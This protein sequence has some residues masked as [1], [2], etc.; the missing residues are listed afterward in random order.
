MARVF[1]GVIFS[2]QQTSCARTRKIYNHL[3]FRYEKPKVKP[4]PIYLIVSTQIDREYLG[5]CFCPQLFVGV[6]V[7]FTFN[8]S[9]YPSTSRTSSV[10]ADSPILGG[11]Q[12]L[13][14]QTYAQRGTTVV[15][16]FVPFSVFSLSNLFC[17]CFLLV[18]FRFS[19]HKT[20]VCAVSCLLYTVR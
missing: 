17:C 1:Y 11:I 8:R 19:I 9:F 2:I 15:F 4:R 5:T 18:P 3:Y 7:C 20:L 16:N 10:R 14:S 12:A 13:W 6:S